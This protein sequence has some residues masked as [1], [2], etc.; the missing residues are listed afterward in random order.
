MSSSQDSGNPNP[1]TPAWGEQEPWV[2]QLPL[3]C[4]SFHCS[5]MGKCHKEYMCHLHL[6]IF[7]KDGNWIYIE[8]K[9]YYFRNANFLIDCPW[10]LGFVTVSILIMK[11]SFRAR[12]RYPDTWVLMRCSWPPLDWESRCQLP[13]V[14]YKLWFILSCAFFCLHMWSKK[15]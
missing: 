13:W 14:Q 10:C 15:I 6:L 4:F 9:T 7:S 8:R 3:P 12:G 5:K 2:S 11:I 1:R